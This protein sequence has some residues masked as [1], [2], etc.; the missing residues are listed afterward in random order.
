MYWDSIHA[1]HIVSYHV[2]VI[3]I[4]Q[5]SDYK[6]YSSHEALPAHRAESAEG[7]KNRTRDQCLL[8]TQPNYYCTDIEHVQQPQVLTKV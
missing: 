8:M 4:K 6:V 3:L 2:T 1:F 7:P 5:S